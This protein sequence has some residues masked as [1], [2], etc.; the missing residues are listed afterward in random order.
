MNRNTLLTSVRT[1]ITDIGA[2][3][4][5]ALVAARIFDVEAP[6]EVAVG[7]SDG[8]Y[9]VFKLGEDPAGDYLDYNVT[10]IESELKVECWG[11]RNAGAAVLR[12]LSDN[13]F[14]ALNGSALT[15]T[16]DHDA[17]SFDGQ[18]RGLAEPEGELIKICSSFILRGNH[19][20]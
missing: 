12:T 3:L 14:A 4:T 10:V 16:T 5:P 17:A 6:D 11:H 8:P 13:L 20:T 2:G 19:L 18:D 9:V 1:R 15:Q 7:T